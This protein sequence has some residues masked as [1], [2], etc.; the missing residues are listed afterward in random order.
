MA[1]LPDGQESP[2]QRST[3]TFPT[4]RD[5]VAAL[6]S[7]QFQTVATGLAPVDDLAPPS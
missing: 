7:H 4:K 1:A 3:A 5:L 2:S 6:A